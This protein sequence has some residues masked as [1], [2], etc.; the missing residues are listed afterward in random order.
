V[1]K[2]RFSKKNN[3]KKVLDFFRLL[4]LITIDMHLLDIN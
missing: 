4:Q 3:N 2:I 1:C